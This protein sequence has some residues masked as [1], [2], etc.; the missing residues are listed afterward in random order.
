MRQV[1][2]GNRSYKVRVDVD[3][4]GDLQYFAITVPQAIAKKFE[5]VSL[6]CYSLSSSIVFESG[7]KL[8][9]GAG[10]E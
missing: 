3:K 2:D 7:A 8:R 6:Y 9:S 10:N 5:G 1:G 4:G